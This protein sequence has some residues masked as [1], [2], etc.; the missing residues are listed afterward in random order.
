MSHPFDTD[1]VVADTMPPLD[2]DSDEGPGGDDSTPSDDDSD[3]GPVVADTMPP[4]DNNLTDIQ[5][6][7]QNMLLNPEEQVKKAVE[8]GQ[9]KLTD[10]EKKIFDAAPEVVDSTPLDNAAGEAV[11]Q[12]RD[13]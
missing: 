4:L 2:D 11:N 3:E 7:T 13:T 6:R 10:T 1:A 8:Q 12:V 5:K 9:I